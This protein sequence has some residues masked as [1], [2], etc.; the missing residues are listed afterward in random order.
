MSQPE[1]LPCP[2]CG[3]EPKYG[4]DN[5]PQIV[6]VRCPLCLMT[7]PKEL[8]NQVATLSWNTRFSG[9][10]QKEESDPFP[11]PCMD[12]ADEV[13]LRET[14]ANLATIIAQSIKETRANTH[15]IQ[16]IQSQINS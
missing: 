4:N 1:L 12:P 7:G 9:D 14:V 6:F 16:K 13:T 11:N 8:S 5:T 3:S 2:F 10:V 15:E